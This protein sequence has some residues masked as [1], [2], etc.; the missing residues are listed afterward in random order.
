M[1]K[2]LGIG[3]VG[4]GGVSGVHGAAYVEFS[5]VCQIIAVCDVVRERALERMRE[6][7]ASAVYD[8]YQD[9]LAD[10]RIDA[11][12]ICTPHY[13]HAPMTIDSARAGKHVLVEK[14]MAINVRQATEMIDAA[15]ENGVTLSV[16]FQNQ[17][18]PNNQFIHR[19]V[20][21]VLGEIH[22]SYLITHHYRD[23]N[24]YARDPWRGTWE[25]EGGGVFVNQGI[26]AWDMFQSY[27][28]GV[29]YAIGYWANILH[30]T[31]EVEDIGYGLVEFKNGSHGKLFT[32]TCWEG[33]S[34]MIIQGE[35]G[36]I[37]GSVEEMGNCWFEL[38]DKPLQEKLVAEFQRQGQEVQRG[39]EQWGEG[40]RTQI[41]DFLESIMEGREPLV[42]GKSARESIKICDGIHL[43]G[44]P[45][46][47]RLREY[48]HQSFC[49]PES[50]E[51]GRE[52]AWD[53]GR[54]YQRILEIVKSPGRRLETLGSL[55]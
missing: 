23:A 31:I 38:E 32:T 36:R 44:W 6:W 40:H 30:P 22:F 41:R 7:N 16:I 54:L 17:Y 9:L 53:G 51:A 50:V 55:Q 10:D 42:T 13:L 26:H 43:Y 19:R 34:E 14:P 52:Q 27:H 25:Q 11:V 49:L 35:H 8:D 1:D 12:S 24:Y 21:P 15:R 37:V 48:V 5:D 46:A 39:S 18:S 20:L 33:P 3:I 28:G 45:Y 2:R 4:C 47:E 29:D